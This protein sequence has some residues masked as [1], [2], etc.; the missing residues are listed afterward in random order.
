SPQNPRAG[1]EY[2]L[3]LGPALRS[4]ATLGIWE[5]PWR[6]ARYPTY[7]EIGHLESDFFRPE[8]WRPEYP[9]PAFERMLPA[10]AF[11]AARIL[12][13]LSDEAIRGVVHAGEFTDP[14]GERYLADTL[15][16]RRDKTVAHYFGQVDPLA[17]FEVVD[18]TLR[19]RN[20]GVEAR[21]GAAD[22]YE[23]QWHR[24]SNGDGALSPLG[25]P[26]RAATASLAIPGDSGPYVMARIRT[27]G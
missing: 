21:V 14:E 27:V 9:N 18:G 19:F 1:N 15:I 23:Y 16:R 17:D 6:S 13:R 10:D 22:G 12:F 4:A 5:R 11:W 3:E 2:V 24:F 26:G 25:G 7:P 8:A 20:L